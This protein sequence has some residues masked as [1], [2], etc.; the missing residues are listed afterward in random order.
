MH[1]TVIMVEVL[2]L[3]HRELKIYFACASVF[4][5]LRTENILCVRQ[6]FV[7]GG[8]QII[9]ILPKHCIK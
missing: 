5:S 4:V 2:L 9:I 3:F 6:C 7:S 8:E 1:V